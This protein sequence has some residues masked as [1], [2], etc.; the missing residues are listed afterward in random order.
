MEFKTLHLFLFVIHL[1]KSDRK[2]G[3]K[4]KQVRKEGRRTEKGGPREK[5]GGEGRRRGDVG[6]RVETGGGERGR[7]YST[8]AL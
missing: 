4:K 6:R 2:G 3:K 7:D 1:V 8:K 5:D